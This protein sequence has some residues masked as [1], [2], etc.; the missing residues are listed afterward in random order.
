MAAMEGG[1]AEVTVGV[2]RALAS[3]QGLTQILEAAETV[4]QRVAD[5]SA[6]ASGMMAEATTVKDA[7]E[8]IASVSEENSASSEEV[9]A[10]AASMDSQMEDVSR[11]AQSLADT[12]LGMQ[13]LVTQYAPEELDAA[14]GE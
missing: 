2:E 9:S 5:I 4:N 3:Q 1:D 10:N 11:L 13:Q 12:A 7:I 14:V 6:A 8:S